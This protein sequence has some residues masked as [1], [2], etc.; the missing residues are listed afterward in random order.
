[1]AGLKAPFIE[2]GVFVMKI[3]PLCGLLFI[4]FL[5]TVFVSG[6]GKITAPADVV[7]PATPESFILLGGGDGEARFRWV[8]N[9]EPDFNRYLIYRSTITPYDYSGFTQIAELKTNEYVDRF[10]SYDLTYF[11]YITAIDNAGNESNPTGILDVKPVNISSPPSPYGLTVY[12]HNNPNLNVVEFKITWIPPIISDLGY[13]RIYRGASSDFPVDGTTLVDSTQVSLFTDVMQRSG[14]LYYYKVVCV[15]L[16]GKVSVAGLPDAD[17]ILGE[18]VLSSPGNRTVQA[19]PMI[20]SWNAVDHAVNYQVFVGRG[21]MS[22]VIWTS[23]TTTL[24]QMQYA[25]PALATDAIYYWW[26]GAYSKRP[27][28]DNTGTMITPDVNT[29][30][31]IWSFFVR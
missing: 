14:D 29:T 23:N 11:Y 3:K 24:V 21:P 16:G 5:F 22:N 12:G 20:F 15:D 25:G 10:L 7:P 13:F 19:Q 2:C 17:R 18:V 6:C 8:P 30:S 27:Y 28:L 31:K 9:G 1:V 4:A 26:V